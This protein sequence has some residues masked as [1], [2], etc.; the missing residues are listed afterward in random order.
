MDKERT[1]SNFGSDL[2]HNEECGL[3]LSA[4][5]LMYPC[6]RLQLSSSCSQRMLW[7]KVEPALCHTVF[8]GVLQL[9]G[10]AST[11]YMD[12]RAC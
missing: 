11:T 3:P 12:R 10:S 8:H 1:G 6:A 4:M 5:H 9:H 2:T 7:A